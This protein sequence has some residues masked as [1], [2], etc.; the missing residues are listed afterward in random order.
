[1]QSTKDRYPGRPNLPPRC[2]LLVGP[3]CPQR[4]ELRQ[5]SLRIL[6]DGRRREI[7]PSPPSTQCRVESRTN[8][9]KP[10]QQRGHWHLR[11]GSVKHIIFSTQRPAGLTF[12][13]ATKPT[14]QKR[15]RIMPRK[16]AK[17]S[18]RRPATMK[19]EPAGILRRNTS[20]P[21]SC[22]KL[23]RELGHTVARRF[24][25]FLNLLRTSSRIR[26]ARSTQK[27]GVNELHCAIQGHVLARMLRGCS[28]MPE[29]ESLDTLVHPS[30]DPTTRHN[31]PQGGK[32]AQNCANLSS[33]SLRGAL[34]SM[35]ATAR[36][37]A[38]VLLQ[39]NGMERHRCRPCPGLVFGRKRGAAE[40]LQRAA[41]E[42]VAVLPEKVV[43]FG[44]RSW[45]R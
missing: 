4:G 41:A 14:K 2:G 17:Q 16:R 33:E 37:I 24:R 30:C 36:S 29:T 23:G 1:M 31:T 40:E 8:T 45:Q 44:A 32:P 19:R 35:A 10:S 42:I 11:V 9:Q 7:F 43:A 12:S 26:G 38:W 28:F 22:L 18:Y 3:V 6:A 21:L 20:E 25:D 13:E 39:A 5:D 34:L 15:K 27:H